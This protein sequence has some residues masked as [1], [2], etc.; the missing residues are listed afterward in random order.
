MEF[1][2]DSLA[3]YARQ[4]GES[5]FVI[6]IM[7]VIIISGTLLIR[8]MLI[9]YGA[10][11]ARQDNIVLRVVEANAKANTE[12]NISRD[13]L[14]TSITLL[15]GKF[16]EIVINFKAGFN[17]M[18]GRIKTVEEQQ[19]QLQSAVTTLTEVVTELADI[20]REKEAK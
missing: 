17:E 9:T 11:T 4:N 10:D 2:F 14:A 15:A 6:V 5:A 12:A 16:D 19:T 13:H 8:K 7:A 20:M 18:N 3:E 1:L